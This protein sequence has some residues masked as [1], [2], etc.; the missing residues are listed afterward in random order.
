M[1]TD[2]YEQMMVGD[3]DR[4]EAEYMAFLDG[5]AEEAKERRAIAY[6]DK[7]LKRRAASGYVA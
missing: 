6:I 3:E 2:V 4:W 1:E 7:V 5:G